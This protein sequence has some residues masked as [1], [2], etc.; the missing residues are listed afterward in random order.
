MTTY[1]KTYAE[2]QQRNN[3]APPNSQSWS[4]QPHIFHNCPPNSVSFRFQVMT[5]RSYQNRNAPIISCLRH[6]IVCAHGVVHLNS[7][8]LDRNSLHKGQLSLLGQCIREFPISKPSTR[9]GSSE[10]TCLDKNGCQ[11]RI[12]FSFIS[13]AA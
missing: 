3:H 11:P 4:K 12:Q 13:D 7:V 5:S 2:A 8:S 6:N 1:K 10:L 9:N